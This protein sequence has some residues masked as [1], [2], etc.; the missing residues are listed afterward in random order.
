MYAIASDGSAWQQGMNY[1]RQLLGT[2]TNLF[3]L[4]KVPE[5]TIRWKNLIPGLFGS[6]LSTAGDAFV[7]GYN[8]Q[9]RDEFGIANPK[10]GQPNYIVSPL[11]WTELAAAGR[12]LV[13]IDRSRALWRIGDPNDFGFPPSLGIGLKRIGTTS[14]WKQVRVNRFLREPAFVIGYNPAWHGVLLKGDGSLWT[15]GYGDQGQLG[16]GYPLGMRRLDWQQ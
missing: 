11:N 15:F 14:D 10:E 3:S 1:D 8:F 9:M 5:T 13:G 6:G 16:N 12:S 4:V 7:W 2:T